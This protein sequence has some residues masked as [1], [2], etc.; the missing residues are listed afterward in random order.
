MNSGTAGHNPSRL[1]LVGCGAVAEMYYAPVLR[2]LTE[3]GTLQVTTLIDPN[4]ARL[5]VLAKSFPGARRL[6]DAADVAGGE[7]DLAIVASPQKFH[8]EQSMALLRLGIA[9]LCEKPMASSLAE[10]KAMV[11]A[12]D[13]ARRFLAV[14][15]FRRFFPSSQLV[16]ELVTGEALGKPVSF[17]WSEGGLF[18]WPAA[19]SSFFRKDSSPGGVFAD[20]GAHVVDLLLLWFGE[21]S[22]FD[23]EDDAMGGLEANARLKL[24][25]EGGVRGSVR[26]S[27]DSAIPNGT[28]IHFE[29]GSVWFNGASADS[30]V[31]QFRG[32]GHAVRGALHE[33]L[34]P[35]SRVDRG[36]GEAA[37]T[38]PR[39]FLEQVRNFTRA[40]RH[41][42][43]LRVPGRAAL[44]SMKLIEDCY[45]S[46][47]VMAMPWLTSDELEGLGRLAG[48]AR[49]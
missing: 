15:L 31:M 38:Y 21:P 3:S 32:C 5:E 10:A 1:A 35:D 28:R 25:F 9:V 37:W 39:S 19:S 18:N 27:R 12:A 49:S 29:R 16:R 17:E 14:G 7:V 40:A 41:E 26:L 30:V 46:R 34:P 23:Y 6:N 36:V 2:Q 43:P 42:E 22:S 4:A 13:E 45:R 33:S 11:D 8:A 48:G 44:P 20:V 47:R 24:C